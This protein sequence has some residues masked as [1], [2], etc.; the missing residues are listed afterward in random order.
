MKNIVKLI[1]V[2]TLLLGFSKTAKAGEYNCGS[3]KPY[4]MGGKFD[5]NR[6]NCGSMPIA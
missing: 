4:S 2:F 1:L 6:Y 3:S 5:I